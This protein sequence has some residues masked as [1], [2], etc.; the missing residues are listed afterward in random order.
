MKNQF[1]VFLIE[2]TQDQLEVSNPR[3]YIVWF[4]WGFFEM[5]FVVAKAPTISALTCCILSQKL[6]CF[7]PWGGGGVIR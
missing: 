7:Q 5:V 2:Q 3:G 6:L 4:A 1:L